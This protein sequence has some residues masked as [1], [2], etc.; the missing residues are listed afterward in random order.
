MYAAAQ[1]VFSGVPTVAVPATAATVIYPEGFVL[2]GYADDA[3]RVLV[4]GRDLVHR[5]GG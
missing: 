3:G 2:F 5:A 1:T 4:Y